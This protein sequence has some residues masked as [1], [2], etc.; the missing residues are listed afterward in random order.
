MKEK[1]PITVSL[2]TV[3]LIL[4]IIAIIIMGIAIYLILNQKT[5]SDEKVTELSSEVN[6]MEI[7]INN[8]E[9]QLENETASNKEK[10]VTT[11][12]TS[13]TTNTTTNTKN[14]VKTGEY[15]ID[16][17]EVSPDPENYGIASI[18]IK[19]NNKFTID[20]PLGTSYDGTYSLN[21]SKLTCNATEEKIIEGGGDPLVTKVNYTFEF[22]EIAN[23]QLKYVSTN[24][25]EFSYTIGCTYTI[26]L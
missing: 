9:K 17:I 20:M 5:Q 25:S 8:L 6:K 15:T 19:E 2:S 22:E 21:G 12:E 13:T 4:A 24:D 23:G 10:N 16:G 18:T 26:K 14:T 7:T 3:F 11:N 1:K